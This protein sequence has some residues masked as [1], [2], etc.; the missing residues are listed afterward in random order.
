MVLV[1]PFRKAMAIGGRHPVRPS[2]ARREFGDLGVGA[3]RRAI[4]DGPEPE[5][6]L[7]QFAGA[8][9]ARLGEQTGQIARACCNVLQ[10][11]SG[12]CAA[13]SLGLGGTILEPCSL[14]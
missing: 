1:C 10:I 9:F 12:R 13:T 7:S 4:G 14:C 11:D 3:W 2:H 8:M 6:T 5:T